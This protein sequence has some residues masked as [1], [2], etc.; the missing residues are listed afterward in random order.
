MS[1]AA[2][3]MQG[4]FHLSD[5]DYETIAR[6]AHAH[7]GI[8]LGTGKR[9]LVYSRLAKQVRRRGMADFADYV[10]LLRNDADARREQVET[11]IELAQRL[12]VASG[13]RTTRHHR[14]SLAASLAGLALA[15]DTRLP[16]HVALQQRDRGTHGD[17]RGA[18]VPDRRPRSLVADARD[19][20]EDGQRTVGDAQQPSVSDAHLAPAGRDPA[21]EQP[22]GRQLGE[23]RGDVELHP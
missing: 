13:G 3:P 23:Q 5:G 4:E 18:D 17:E 6:M 12:V 16:P 14:D 10:A 21:E 2:A 7:A 8:M 15:A 11:G 1:A 22:T 20:R 9:Q 19:D